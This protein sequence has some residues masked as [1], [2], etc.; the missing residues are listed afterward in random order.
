MTFIPQI[1]LTNLSKTYKT[2]SNVVLALKNIDLCINHGEFVAIMGPSASGKST[3][4]NILGLLDSFD[5]GEYLLNNRSINN[6]HDNELAKI[7]NTQIGFVFQSFNLLSH[8]N[9]IENIALPLY[10]KAIPFKERNEKAL[11]Y[12]K[13]TGLAEWSHHLPDE[14]SGGQKQRVAITR[15]LC[16][17][18]KLILADEPTGALDTKTSSEIM[19]LFTSINKLGKTIIIVTHEWEIAKRTNRIIQLI[20]G[21]ISSDEHI[22]LFPKNEK[23]IL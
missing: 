18:P 14:L 3:L 7:R 9:A 8:R 1:Q 10:Y 6:L 2:S 11:H 15:A 5:T 20:D 17:E 16:T 12:L 22:T 13:K 19:D 4:L 21:R 23:P